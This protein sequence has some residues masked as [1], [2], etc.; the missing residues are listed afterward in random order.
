M[1]LRTLNTRDIVDLVGFHY[2]ALMNEQRLYSESVFHGPGDVEDLAPS[3]SRMQDEI[4]RRAKRAAAELENDGKYQRFKKVERRLERFLE[5]S[6]PVAWV[7]GLR[8]TWNRD[9]VRDVYLPN[10][11]RYIRHAESRPRYHE[12]KLDS[13]PRMI[14]QDLEVTVPEIGD[15]IWEA[16]TNTSQGIFL[17]KRTVT[18]VKFAYYHGID[19]EIHVT[20]TLDNVQNISWSGRVDGNEITEKSKTH[21]VRRFFTREAAQEYLEHYLNKLESQIS[22]LREKLNS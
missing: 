11:Q 13:G 20:V 9:R 1:A 14:P 7:T 15:S 8:F 21:G 10:V 6:A 2:N 3:L 16:W 5:G 4:R 18:N 19:D 12:E 22:E 17:K